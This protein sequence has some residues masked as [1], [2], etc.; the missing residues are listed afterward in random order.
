MNPPLGTIDLMHPF[1]DVAHPTISAPTPPTSTIPPATSVVR[2][3]TITSLPSSA[4]LVSSRDDSSL[5]GVSCK[6][7]SSDGRPYILAGLVVVPVAVA[8]EAPISKKGGSGEVEEEIPTLTEGELG[9]SV[10]LRRR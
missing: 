2:L 1:M 4:A 9:S 5:I 7:G 6:E 3:I 8:A 10:G